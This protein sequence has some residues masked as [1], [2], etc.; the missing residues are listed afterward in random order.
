MT[1]EFADEEHTMNDGTGDQAPLGV[2]VGV[3][4]S[5]N[6]ARAALWAAREALLRAVPLTMVSALNLPENAVSLSGEPSEFAQRRRAEGAALLKLTAEALQTEFPQLVVDTQLSD[7]SPVRALAGLGA[8]SELLVTGTRGL[9]GFTGLLLGSVTRKLAAHATCPL[10]TVRG[11]QPATVLDEVV[12]GIG[13]RPEQAGPAIAYAFNAAQRCGA[14]LHAV[15][16]WLPFAAHSGQMGSYSSDFTEI[17]DEEQRS[18]ERLL[19]PMRASF[20]DVSV[21]VSVGRGNPVPILIEAARDTRLV[22]VGAPRHHGP[23]S[24]GAGYVVEGML[25]HS[26]TPVAV[27]PEP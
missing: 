2:T 16:A 5:D 4:G 10:V 3:D 14:A 7:L 18:V 19:E 25:S 12:L 6:A 17:R 20:P 9:G 15:R 23:L 13:E 26:P 21:V 1:G 11:E 22:V 27:V 8:R 24:V